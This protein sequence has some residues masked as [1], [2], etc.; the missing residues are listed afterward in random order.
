MGAFA[1]AVLSSFCAA[2]RSNENK[3][4]ISTPDLHDRMG[5]VAN[6]FAITSISSFLIMI[7]LVMLTEGKKLGQFIT[8]LQ[9]HPILL[10]EVLAS[11]F[12]FTLSTELS[13]PITKKASAVTMSVAGTAMRATSMIAVALKLGESLGFLKLV[14]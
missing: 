9:T 7:P 1:T 5:S 2:F 13:A 6:Q 10:P 4:L 3:R 11:G 14:G 12:W 8:L